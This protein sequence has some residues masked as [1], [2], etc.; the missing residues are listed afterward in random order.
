[1][2]G[3]SLSADGCHALL[4]SMIAGSGRIPDDYAEE[5][6]P[7][8]LLTAAL[9]QEDGPAFEAATALLLLDRLQGGAGPDDLFWHWDSFVDHYRSADPPVRA[10]L[11]QGYAYC[12]RLGLVELPD[13]PQN[14]DLCTQSRDDVEAGLLELARSL[15]PPDIESVSRADSGWNARRH[16]RALVEALTERSGRFPAGEP[17]FPAEVVQLTAMNPQAPGF[18][19][20]M[21]LIC[22]NALPTGDETDNISYHWTRFASHAVNCDRPERAPIIAAVR[23]LFESTADWEPYWDWSEERINSEAIAIP[24]LPSA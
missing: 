10:A 1:M 8:L 15:S 17:W 7:C 19:Q 3:E 9:P 14:Q 5:L 16:A 18:L 11:M 4:E 2:P 6:H 13:P 20:C 23:Y 12:E 24:W 22:L 21:A